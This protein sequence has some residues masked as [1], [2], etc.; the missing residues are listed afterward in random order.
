MTKQTKKQTALADT[1]EILIQHNKWRR[2]DDELVKM[3]DPTELDLAIDNA[4]RILKKVQE[5][6]I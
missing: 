3:P 1:I 6:L 5:V 4:V 2:G